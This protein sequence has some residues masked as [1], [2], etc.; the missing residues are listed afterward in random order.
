MLK[1]KNSLANKGEDLEGVM[2]CDLFGLRKYH[3]IGRFR[4][5]SAGRFR[6]LVQ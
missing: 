3:G 5:P 6:F 2:E 1:N 4:V